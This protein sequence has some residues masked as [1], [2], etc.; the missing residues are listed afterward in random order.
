[1]SGYFVYEKRSGKIS[2]AGDD[3]M[4]FKNDKETL[5]SGMAIIKSDLA[6]NNLMLLKDF[7]V[8]NG[9]VKN[10]TDFPVL[11]V[12]NGVIT[13]IPAETLVTWPDGVMTVESG[14]FEFD[15]NVSGVFSFD[16]YSVPYKP[17]TLEVTY[18]V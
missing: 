15:C 11:N 14:S 3:D 17:H 9:V 5:E 12:N 4:E 18:S 1:M 16:F 13:N 8:K 6:F 2:S 10:T 7:W